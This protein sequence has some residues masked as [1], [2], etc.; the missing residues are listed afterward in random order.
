MK[1]PNQFAR[2]FTVLAPML[3]I[4][5]ASGSIIFDDFN[6]NEGHFG[7]ALNASGST[8]NILLASS[9]ADRV[10]A[11]PF[12]GPGHE[13]LVL[14]PTTVGTATRLRFLS[15]A[16]ALANNTPFT[17]SPAEDGWIGVYLKTSDP[18]WTVQFFLD[19]SGVTTEGNGSIPKTLTA[20][21]QWHLYEWNLDDNT[22][23]V[24]GWGTIAG[25]LTGDAPFEDGT[26]SID[27]LIFRHTGQPGTATIDI[28]FVAKSDS[29]SVAGLIPEPS[30]AMLVALGLAGLA[31]RRKR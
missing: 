2:N 3:L 30:S 4:Q 28:D 12:E 29:G 25:I 26:H 15:G 17:T 5:A 21:G 6:I 1:M 22:G 11:A 8:T 19:I 20:D 16:G 7:S 18:G 9:S 31:A 10:T 24:D 27:S 23:G 13:R 14:T